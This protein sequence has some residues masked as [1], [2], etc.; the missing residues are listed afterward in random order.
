MKV[1]LGAHIEIVS[2]HRT[3]KADQTERIKSI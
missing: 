3:S 1:L 2:T